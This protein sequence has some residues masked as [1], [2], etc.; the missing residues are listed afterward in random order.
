[1]VN[2]GAIATTSLV[3]GRRR[4]SDGST[5]ARRTL[6]LRRPRARRS[7][8]RSTHPHRRRTTATESIARLLAERRRDRLRPGRRSRSLHAAELAGRDGARP[9]RD[10]RDARRR[11]RQPTH[12]HPGRQPVRLPPHP[13][14]DGDRRSVRDVR[15]LALR[16]RAAR[17]RAGS[18]AASSRSRPARAGWART[19][20]ALDAAGNSVKGHSSPV[21]HTARSASTCSRRARRPLKS[22][23]L[24]ATARSPPRSRSSSAPVAAADLADER[25]LAEKYAP[26]VRLV[27][28]E[29]E[30]GPGEPYEPLDVDLLLADEP[31][32]ALRGPWNPTDL[33]KIGPTREDLPNRFEYHLDFPGDPLD[34]GCDYELWAAGSP[35]EASRRSTRTSPPSPP[36]ASSR[37]STGSSTPS[38]TSTTRTR[39]TGR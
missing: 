7:T 15:R 19:P 36:P 1:M 16:R 9:R 34:A 35:R 26:V 37:C 10:G 33:V 17:A 18:A 13:R 3:P 30:C 21:P 22:R 28:Q 4:R 6:A 25:A 31:T 38:T 24:G 8:R 5:I 20:H 11:R 32:V 39:A 14:R 23:A 29:E 12:R 27:E 2:P